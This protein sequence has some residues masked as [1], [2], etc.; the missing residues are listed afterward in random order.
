MSAMSAM[1]IQCLQNLFRRSLIRCLGCLS[2][3]FFCP[4]QPVVS[5]APPG[6]T[7]FSLV[8]SIAKD[9]LLLRSK[10]Y[11][12]FFFSV[13]FFIWFS[14]VCRVRFSLARAPLRLGISTSGLVHTSH[15]AFS[16]APYLSAV[17]WSLLPFFMQTLSNMFYSR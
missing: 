7:C 6:A 15:H 13:C 2:A 3:S 1:Q 10:Q 14:R 4:L 16:F 5:R 11:Y 12:Y 8:F 17:L 9:I